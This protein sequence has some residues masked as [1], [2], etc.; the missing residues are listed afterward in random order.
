LCIAKDE[1]FI[2]N[3]T[4]VVRRYDKKFAGFKCRKKEF[5]KKTAFNP[6]CPRRPYKFFDKKSGP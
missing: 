4:G 5:R 2:A 3:F 1:D 6:E